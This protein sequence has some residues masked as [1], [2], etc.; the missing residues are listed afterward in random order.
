MKILTILLIIIVLPVLLSAWNSTGHKI[1]ATLAYNQL[2]P[3]I[4][5]NI[6]ETLKYHPQYEEWVKEIPADF[7]EGL[8]LLMKASVWPDKIRRSESP[9]DHPTW[10]YVN[11]FILRN[12]GTLDLTRE[13]PQNDVIWGINKSK[14][15][16]STGEPEVKAAYL[17]WLTHLIGDIHQP[18]HCASV[19]SDLF[20][21]GDRGGN[22][23]WVRKGSEPIKLHFYWDMLPGRIENITDYES[24][25][26]QLLAEFPRSSF[27]NLDQ[28]SDPYIWGSEGTE[29]ALE[30]AHQN[31]QLPE[32]ADPSNA[33][34]LSEN[35]HIMAQK[36]YKQRIML[37]SYRFADLL[38]ILFKEDSE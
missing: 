18:M 33:E 28:L 27:N 38:E 9:Y 22:N 21:E 12:E 8:F 36:I 5:E 3:I 11:F 23:I 37:A 34:P 30:Y 15:F 13:A 31:L 20:P 14:E 2:D 29:I 35:Y 10:H 1:I 7:N 25:C 26:I 4:Q 19:K 17:S 24:A 16:I 32:I 6:T